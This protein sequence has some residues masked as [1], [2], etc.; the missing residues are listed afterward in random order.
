M[1]DPDLVLHPNHV[2]GVLEAPR[3]HDIE[4]VI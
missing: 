1:A 2:R 3:R 4:G